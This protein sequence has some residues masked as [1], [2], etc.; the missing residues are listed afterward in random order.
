MKHPSG[1]YDVIVAGGGHAGVEAAY[2]ASSLGCNTALI[3]LDKNAVA[4]MS[5]NPAIGGLAK[6]QIVREIDILGGVMPRVADQSGI[7]FKMLNRSKGRSVWSPR[8]QIDKR[9]YE[10]KILFELS[11]QNHLDIIEVEVVDLIEEAGHVSG[12]VFRNGERI[13]CDQLILTFGTFLNGLVHVGER[14]ISAGRMGEPTSEGITE[15]LV[16]RGFISGRLKTGTPPRLD[17]GSIDWSKTTPSFGDKH[18]SPFSFS[19]KDFQPPN[20]PCHYIK[21]TTKTHDVI[22]KN[23]KRSPMFSGD[24]FGVGPRYCPS[25]EDKIHRFAHH[26]SHLLFLEP[27]WNRSSQIYLNGFSTSLPEDVQLE[28]LRCISG[29]ENVQFFRPGYAIEYDFFPPAQLHAT[30]ESKNISGLFFAGQIN[31][32]SGYEEA[33]AQ[34]LLAGINA[35]MNV[36]GKDSLTL[37]R[38]EAY[39]GVLVDDLITKDTM[40]PYRMFTSRAEFRL[41]LRYSNTDRRL[42]HHAKRIGL[43]SEDYCSFLENKLYQTDQLLSEFEASVSPDEINPALQQLDQPTLIQ[44]MP[45]TRVLKRPGVSIKSFPERYFK[46]IESSGYEKGIKEEIVSEVEATIKYSGY[47]DRQNQQV[48]QLKKQE[49][50]VIPDGLDYHAIPSLSNEGREK[51]LFVRPETLG[52]AMRISG[53]SPADISVLAVYLVK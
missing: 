35:S 27:E 21:T 16:S 13:Y 9:L 39:I 23:I 46:S 25:I 40:E 32:T 29:F 6:G 33:A 38:N 3:T 49:S 17:A 2:I 30:L 51:L 48:A 42:L 4:R 41:L 47:I 5:C 12:V 52:Q 50:F 24:V 28:S 1:R 53:V 31:G 18:P 7:Q 26:D 43:L 19:T 15:S 8:A 10:K 44:Q 22:Q 11:M 20:I 45:A 34:G 36:K 37:A 14:K